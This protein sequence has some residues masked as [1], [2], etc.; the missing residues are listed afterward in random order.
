M[1]RAETNDT[2][3]DADEMRRFLRA[4]SVSG[5]SSPSRHRNMPIATRAQDRVR[6]KARALGWATFA[7]GEWRITDDGRS[8]LEQQ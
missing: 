6:R 7:K 5:G 4:L 8:A 3:T 1:S 2:G